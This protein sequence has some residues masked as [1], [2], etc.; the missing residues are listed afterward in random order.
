MKKI[1]WL[2]VGIT[3]GVVAARKIAG[4]KGALGPAGINRAVGR[5][6]D[7]LHDFAGAVV[8]GMGERET[9]LRR[10]LGLDTDHEVGSRQSRR[11]H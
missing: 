7:S 6:S 11:R 3:I 8:A 10:A 1:F 5:A 4:A 2:G 9:E